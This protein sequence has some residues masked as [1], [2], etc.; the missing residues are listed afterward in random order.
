[1]EEEWSTKLGGVTSP[2]GMEFFENKAII[3]D[4]SEVRLAFHEKTRALWISKINKTTKIPG[5]H[6]LY[7]ADQELTQR[8]LTSSIAFNNKLSAQ[9]WLI[10]Q[11]IANTDYYLGG[12]K[13]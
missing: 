2:W 6:L 5:R 11:P 3:E 13:T 10:P 7:T 9:C 4:D 1:M 12:P 8:N